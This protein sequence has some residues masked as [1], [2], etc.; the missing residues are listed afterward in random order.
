MYFF[1]SILGLLTTVHQWFMDLHIYYNLHSLNNSTKVTTLG[2]TLRL[3]QKLEIYIFF[4][5]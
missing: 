5:K 2:S 4:F 3:I 1:F